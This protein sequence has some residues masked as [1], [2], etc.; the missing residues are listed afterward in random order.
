VILLGFSRLL[1]SSRMAS[2]TTHEST[3]A[4]EGARAMLETLKATAFEEV[5]AR[6]NADGSDDPGGNGTAPG[7]GFAVRGLEPVEGD[8]D[9]QV[10]E[11]L[12]PMIGS[13]LR[14]DHGQAWLFGPVDDLDGD[15]NPFGPDAV[16]HAGDYRLLPVV[17]RV[18]WRGSGG[19]AS[20]E[21]RTT[22][23]DF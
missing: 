18:Q 16:D 1:L 23:G 12:F 4:K 2:N 22:L 10:G 9:G 13:E 15:G 7:N 21:F 19:N 6:F 17:V 5:F 14:E 3:V 20:V 11:I 8:A